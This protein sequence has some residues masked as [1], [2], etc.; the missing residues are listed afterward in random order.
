MSGLELRVT[1]LEEQVGGIRE[2][3]AVIQTE[4]KYTVG[5]LGRIEE[6]L[7]EMRDRSLWSLAAALKHP[8]TLIMILTVLGGLLG[9]N[10]LLAMADTIADANASETV[11][12]AGE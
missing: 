7:D 8:Q 6:R 10:A 5:A 4:Q 2:T 9:N 1:N 11:D 3:V 12:I